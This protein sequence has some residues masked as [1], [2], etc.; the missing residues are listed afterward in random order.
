MTLFLKDP[1]STCL[2]HSSFTKAMGTALACGLLAT[3]AVGCS[4]EKG[5]ESQFRASDG[6]TSSLLFYVGLQIRPDD[7]SVPEKARGQVLACWYRSDVKVA[8]INTAIANGSMT[9]EQA[10]Q[11][12]FAPGNV[13]KRV[14]Q[15]PSKC[16]DV[17]TRAS[18]VLGVQTDYTPMCKL[19]FSKGGAIQGQEAKSFQFLGDINIGSLLGT[20]FGNTVTSEAD[21]FAQNNPN[22]PLAQAAPIAANFVTSQF[23]TPSKSSTGE[24]KAMSAEDVLPEMLAAAVTTQTKNDPDN[25]WA[26]LFSDLSPLFSKKGSGTPVDP[27][28]TIGRSVGTIF[29][30]RNGQLRI[31]NMSF[32]PKQVGDVIGGLLNRRQQNQSTTPAETTSTTTAPAQPAP[33]PAQPASTGPA[34]AQPA[35]S[36]PPNTV[37]SPASELDLA[38][39]KVEMAQL[40]AITADINKTVGASPLVRVAD[41][42]LTFAECP[43]KF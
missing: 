4:S 18:T 27:F 3:A 37:P 10:R 28:S 29:G 25:K 22:N 31:G 36:T 43:L 17:P 13:H 23:G 34:S 40:N 41:A 15:Y 19:D 24:T 14:T 20:F 26:R 8:A 11:A 5:S 33:A 35:A 9:P 42:N 2:L 1:P 30:D 39:P 7:M 38:H 21:K 32:D 16:E 12:F 6:T